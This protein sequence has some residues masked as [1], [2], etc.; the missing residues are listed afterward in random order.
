MP[1]YTYDAV[2]SC[3][4]LP[5][6]FISLDLVIKAKSYLVAEFSP[7]CHSSAGGDKCSC[8]RLLHIHHHILPH[9]SE[10]EEETSSRI[11]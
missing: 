2:Y 1:G 3:E 8:H 11:Y 6:V 7:G 10:N 5:V 4:C 9:V